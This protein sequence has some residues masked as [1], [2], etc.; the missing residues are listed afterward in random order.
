MGRLSGPFD[1]DRTDGN[2]EVEH[3]A[4]YYYNDLIAQQ[5]DAG[6]PVY[7]L[8]W[9]NRGHCFY[10]GGSYAQARKSYITFYENGLPQVSLLRLR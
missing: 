2:V 8:T 6:V 4:L 1:Y 3:G 5:Q 10:L 9:Y 7:P